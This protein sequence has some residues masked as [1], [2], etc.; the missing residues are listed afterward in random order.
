MLLPV[1]SF[2]FAVLRC[3][4][5]EAGGASPLK[6]S[7]P[8]RSLTFLPVIFFAVF[9]VLSMLVSPNEKVLAC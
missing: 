2:S 1:I 6:M 3:F 4:S 9:G 7:L 5:A 8:E